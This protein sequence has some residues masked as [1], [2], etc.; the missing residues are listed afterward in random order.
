MTKRLF[1]ITAS[2]VALVL[3][4]PVL[5]IIALI[6][7][8]GSRGGAIYS[9]ERVGKGG[10]PFRVHK[11][12]SMS[13]D[14][15]KE[16]QLTVGGRDPR[17][18]KAGHILR[19]TK[20]DELPQLYNILIG[21]MSI[22]GPRPEVPRYVKLYTESQREVLDVRPGLTD[23]ASIAYVN[24]NEILGASEDP[25]RTYIEEVMPHKLELNRKYIRES[26]LGTDLQIIVRTAGAILR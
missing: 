25:E 17:I 7:S 11:F 14:A 1:D 12:R 9:Q 4:S 21:D 19:K 5:G 6:V 10:R 20:L 8:T 2:C 22:V 23:Y 16:G 3:L 13:L 18:T 24:E 26:G 15:D